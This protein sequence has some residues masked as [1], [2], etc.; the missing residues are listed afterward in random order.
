MRT[1]ISVEYKEQKIS[2]VGKPYT[3]THIMVSDGTVAEF[4]GDEVRVGD[5][6]EVFLHWGKIKARFTP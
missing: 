6:V 4:Y 5:S 2:K 1:V 3:I